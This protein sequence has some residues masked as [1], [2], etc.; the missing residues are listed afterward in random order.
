MW[1]LCGGVSER[2][3]ELASVKFKAQVSLLLLPPAAR[4]AA[5]TAAPLLLAHSPTP[6]CVCA[7]ARTAASSRWNSKG[8]QHKNPKEI[9]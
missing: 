6:S 3:G 8:G 4:T 9:W 2:F 1:T 7:R 5:R